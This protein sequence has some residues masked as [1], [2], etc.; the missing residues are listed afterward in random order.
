MRRSVAVLTLLLSFSL[1]VSAQR[2]KGSLNIGYSYSHYTV[3]KLSGSSV[4]GHFSKT[5]YNPLIIGLNASYGFVNRNDTLAGEQQ[6][7]TF[8]VGLAGYYAFINNEQQQLKAGAGISGRFFDDNWN[9]D[10]ERVINKSAFK[11]G[12]SLQLIYDF[13]FSEQWL[14]GGQAR[15]QRY[16][17]DNT[18]FLLGAHM[19]FRF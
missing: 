15:L 17:K 8:S 12:V 2:D 7:K 6:L 18:V 11:P 10:P 16:A 9:L 19:G 4:Y 14:I 3:E 5:F 13:F 1:S